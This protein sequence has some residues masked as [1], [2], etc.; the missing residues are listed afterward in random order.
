MVFA[1]PFR[2]FAGFDLVPKAHGISPARPLRRVAIHMVPAAI[3]QRDGE[4]IHDGMVQRL[5]A[6]LRVHLLRVIRPGADHVMGVMAGMDDDLFNRFHIRDLFAHAEGQVNQ[7]LGLVFGRMFLG[8]GI[9]DGPLGFARFRQRHFV[10]DRA[11]DIL[12]VGPPGQNPGNHTVLTFIN[13]RRR[14]L[15][16]HA[17]IHGF[18]RELAGMGRG[19]GLPG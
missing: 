7:R 6:R 15:A 13:R 9:K 3:L 1:G 17:A 19:I 18:H 12:A 5:A 11:I 10:I 8:V 14:A 16:A 4:D 2:I